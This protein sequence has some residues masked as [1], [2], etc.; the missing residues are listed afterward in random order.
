[1]CFEYF[2]LKYYCFQKVNS[3]ETEG[4]LQVAKKRQS[5]C[6]YYKQIGFREK[7]SWPLIHNHVPV[8]SYNGMIGPVLVKNLIFNFITISKHW[9]QNKWLT[10]IKVY[11]FLPPATVIPFIH[12][13]DVSSA[14]WSWQS[15]WNKCFRVINQ[16]LVVLTFI[17]IFGPQ[18][19]SE[20]IVVTVIFW[21]F[22]NIPGKFTSIL[23]DVYVV[24]NSTFYVCC[25]FHN[26]QKSFA[27]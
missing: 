12:F 22:F 19:K 6:K 7:H 25:I 3:E 27:F 5:R 20:A 15:F 23:S 18:S 1:M 17:L 4:Q 26:L 14:I 16:K 11:N 24:K 9:L 21:K 13:F 2:W 8:F 10:I